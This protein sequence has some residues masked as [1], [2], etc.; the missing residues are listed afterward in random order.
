MYWKEEFLFC[1]S[2]KTSCSSFPF[3]L[4][5]LFC[6]VILFDI[7]LLSHST[8]AALI[9][10]TPFY[11]VSGVQRGRYTACSFHYLLKEKLPPL[12]HLLLHERDCRILFSILC[13]LQNDGM[14]L[15]MSEIWRF[16]IEIKLAM[17]NLK[18]LIQMYL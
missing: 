3:P 16:L 12:I 13:T 17:L 1:I 5:P 8:V 18:S 10:S 4:F 7:C 14:L 9:V 15:E 11:Y 6:I 2:L